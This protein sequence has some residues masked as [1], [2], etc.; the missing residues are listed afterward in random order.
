MCIRDSV[1]T[2]TN[3]PKAPFIYDTG[4]LGGL[5]SMAIALHTHPVSPTALLSLIGNRYVFAHQALASTLDWIEFNLL[6]TFPTL[7]LHFSCL[8]L[9]VHITHTHYTHT[10]YTHTHTHTHI[11]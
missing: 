10:H 11:T 9:Y 2:Q 1:R 3:G 8:Q 4:P 6:T 7:S 5:V